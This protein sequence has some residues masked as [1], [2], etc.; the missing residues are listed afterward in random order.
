M[1]GSGKEILRQLPLE[2]SAHNCMG[3]EDF[4][5]S[6]C[7]RKAFTLLDAWPDWVSG[8]LFIYGPEGCGKSH[9]AHLFADKVRQSSQDAKKVAIISAEQI[10][11]R[12]VK[13][14]AEENQ[15]VVVE[16]VCPRHNDEAL[17]HLFNMFNEQGRYMLWT[18]ENA[19]NRL[20]F[21]LPDLQTRL[22]MLPSAAIEEP[23]D[24]MLQMLIAKLFND[25]QIIIGQDIL[26][27]ILNN[28]RRSFAYI[29]DLVK[30]IDEV[31]LEFQSA[32]NYNIVRK[33]MENLAADESKEPDLFDEY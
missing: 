25:R 17:F 15:V 31:S 30:E 22:N 24:M 7:N 19:A 8:G 33:A 6:D 14:L 21:T 29:R 11:M 12:N 9:L 27:Y 23:D 1:I 3:R 13:R 4:M 16:D 20:H 10:N 26:N 28:A 2:F 32:V 5:V 18:A